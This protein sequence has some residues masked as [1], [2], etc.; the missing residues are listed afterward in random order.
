MKCLTVGEFMANCYIV[1]YNDSCCIIDPGA[2][3]ERIKAEVKDLKV[4]FILLTH[5]HLDH[6]DCV[7]KFDCPIYIHELDYDKLF[8][9]D[10]A[11]Y[12]SFYSKRS[13]NPK[14]LNIIKVKDNDVIPFFNNEFKVIHTPGHTSGGVCYLYKDKLFS[15]DTLFKESIGRTDLPTGNET[16]MHKTVVKLI[17]SLDDKIKVYP[18][19]GEKTSIHDE[20]VNNQ[21]YK[22]Y[23]KQLGI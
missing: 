7:D 1:D 19:H 17:D 10:L 6:I 4:L 22:Y 13:Y 23:K 12:D 16:I 8:E 15:G 14:K 18:G 2:E 9:A 21:F 5:G 20:R 11:G 3:F